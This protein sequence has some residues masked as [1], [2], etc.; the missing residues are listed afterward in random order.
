MK[1]AKIQLLGIILLG[2]IAM[3]PATLHDYEWTLYLSEHSHEGFKN[4]MANSI[5]ELESIG[6][7]DFP[8]LFL[9]AVLVLYLLSYLPDLQSPTGRKIF[10]ILIRFLERRPNFTAQ[11]IRW[12]PYLGFMIVAGV[13]VLVY[14]VHPT[15]WLVGRPRPRV[16][17]K[18]DHPFS[19]WYLIGSHFIS[20][21]KYS[22]SFPSGHT[23]SSFVFMVLAYALAGTSQTR[24]WKLIGY[25]VGIFAFVS[26][27]L[28]AV[29]RSMANA[30]WVTDCVFTIFFD[31]VIIH[32]I[33]HWGYPLNRLL[34][35]Q[36]S[37][38][39]TLPNY[40]ELKLCSNLL[41]GVIGLL[42]VGLGLRALVR[43]EILIFASLAI[44]IGAFLGWW[45]LKRSYQMGFFNGRVW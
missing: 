19:E 10:G 34:A 33:F 17:F 14:T 31:W 12:R 30:H 15:K 32:C 23:A 38:K 25:G 21:G 24:K 45:F 39:L 3:T 36:Q 16:V 20:Q 35:L 37:Q 27:V 41:L 5:F 26:A 2:A 28:M 7:S 11:L 9:I 44:P 42:L 40:F 18:G 29:S 1:S 4:F 43:Q 13:C 8:V 6:G 22:G